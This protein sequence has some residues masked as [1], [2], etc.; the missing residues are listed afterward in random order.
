MSNAKPTAASTNSPPTHANAAPTRI[1]PLAQPKP[2][3]RT[4]Q[5]ARE[6]QIVLLEALLSLCVQQRSLLQSDDL[7]PLT[8]LLNQRQLLIDELVALDALCVSEPGASALQ[9]S[10]PQASPMQASPL[11]TKVREL[12]QRVQAEDE[13]DMLAMQQRMRDAQQELAELR[14][15]S[16]ALGAYA[17][18]HAHAPL[19]QDTHG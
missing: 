6:R 8:D 15:S 7:T 17:T 5:Q 11:Q 12:A 18:T 19:A 13:A 3:P 2:R 16:R 1:E 4:A 9:T 10:P 14:G